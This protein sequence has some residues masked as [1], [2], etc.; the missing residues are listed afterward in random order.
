VRVTTESASETTARLRAAVETSTQS[1]ALYDV[2][3]PEILA[4]SPPARGQLGLDGVDLKAF[5]LVES[6]S[7]PPATRQ[8]LAL[9]NGGQIREWKVRSRLR[10]A[11]GRP[12]FGYA[13]GR[14]L[15]LDSSRRL[16]LAFYPHRAAGP[17]IEAGS[18]SPARGLPT[19]PVAEDGPVDAVQHL[20][21][22]RISQLQGHLWTIAQELAAAGVIQ[23]RDGLPEPSALP[24]LEHLSARQ[25]E[26]LC[27]LLRGERVATMA[28]EMFLSTSTVRSHLGAIYR[29]VGVRSQ[30]ELLELIDRVSRVGPTTR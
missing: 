10:D 5:D 15:E 11:S 16:A 9:I 6:S 29:R 24:A 20:M 7:D 23:V 17:E 8:L 4:L 12:F 13:T 1:V 28:R 27:R 19:A 25:H 22:D 21:A 3:Q 30:V 26:I 2:A 14:T 18:I